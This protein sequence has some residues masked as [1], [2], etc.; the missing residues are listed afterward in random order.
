MSIKLNKV[1]LKNVKN[2]GVLV[3][4]KKV[5]NRTNNPGRPVNKQS[6]R[7]KRL[8]K[9]AHYANVNDKFVSGNAFQVNQSVYKYSAGKDGGLGCIVET[10]FGA[11]VCNVDYI[12]RTKVQGFTFVLGKRVNVQLNLKTLKFVK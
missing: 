4:E 12:G 5:D 8:A 9:Q 6:A 11:H 3:V 1:E 7:Y 2:V 10:I